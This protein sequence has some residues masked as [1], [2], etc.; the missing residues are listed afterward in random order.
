MPHTG[1]SRWTS[2]LAPAL[3]Y[4]FGSAIGLWCI[5]FVLHLPGVRLAPALTGQL[6]LVCQLA[7]AI[8]VGVGVTRSLGR[9]A[10]VKTG[11]MAGVVAAGVN[12]M[13]LGATINPSDP[14]K[15]LVSAHNLAVAIPGF[16]LLG[17]V[18]GGIGGAIGR[19]A[20]PTRR[21]ES[22][23][24]GLWVARFAGVT[25]VAFLPLLL[26][27]G[28][29]TSTQSGMAVPDWPQTYGANMFLYP[30]GAMTNPRV[31]L[32][33]MHRLFGAMVGLTTLMMMV[34]TLAGGPAKWEKGWA[35]A[36][37]LCVVIQGVLGGGRVLQNNPVMAAVH[38]VFAQ[39]VFAMAVTLAVRLTAVYRGEVA[40]ME[41]DRRRRAIATAAL[42]TL[43]L[44]LTLGAAYRHMGHIHIVFTH[45]AFAVIATIF[46]VMAGLLAIK[47]G[48]VNGHRHG[49][50][51][52]IAWLG[53]AVIIVVMLQFALGWVTFLV[54]LGN[55]H[56]GPVPTVEELATAAP[57]PVARALVA[58]AH[59]TN[60]A[61]LLGLA[62]MLA[63]YCRRLT[64][65]F[66]RKNAE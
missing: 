28:L 44:Q 58:T 54:V 36:V 52:V 9:G 29:V 49:L 66:A 64:P 48:R 10:S 13:T 45:A 1:P 42:H 23:E 56:A 22:H 26:A 12:L 47:R 40:P 15:G 5:W 62:T 57:V 37:F 34:L 24:P 30:L 2:L 38:G 63:V 35:V 39:V 21:A 16:L 50:N 65:R 59:Q 32:E 25:A 53:R 4:G 6:L 14:S 55:K 8:I 20:T 11:L 41:G 60:G 31:T 17:A 61:I 18:M 43:L 3:V 51:L 27:G 7:A 46:V 19:T 33:H